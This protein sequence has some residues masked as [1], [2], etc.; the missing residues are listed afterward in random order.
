M[1]CIVHIFG[2]IR[3]NLVIVVGDVVDKKRFPL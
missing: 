3:G 1:H 2:K